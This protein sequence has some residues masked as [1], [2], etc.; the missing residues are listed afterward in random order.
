[1]GIFTDR[2][3]QT[4]QDE[5]VQFRKATGKSKWGL[6][7]MGYKDDGTKNLLGK[8]V[9]LAAIV[10]PR[11]A[12][13]DAGMRVGAKQMVGKNSD[14]GRQLKSTDDEFIA[15]KVASLDFTM[16]AKKAGADIAAAGSAD[17]GG[18]VAGVPGATT[19]EG[20]PDMSSVIKGASGAGGGDMANV[21][22][23]GTGVEFL[24]TD[25]ASTGNQM[26][27]GSTPGSTPAVDGGDAVSNA[28]SSEVGKKLTDMKEESDIENTKDELDKE[29]K[30][31]EQKKAKSDKQLMKALDSAP[32]VISKGAKL[33]QTSKNYLDEEDKSLQAALGRK[34]KADYGTFL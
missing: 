31:E 33:Y 16:A 29:S 3:D 23:G 1:M 15:Q 34:T 25:F 17:G 20:T 21:A 24:D 8:G 9:S 18:D 14:V 13:V 10:D 12:A 27:M 7:A 26:D 32:G 30:E 6:M 5:R 4:R 11:F 22:A 19:T 2:K 28:L